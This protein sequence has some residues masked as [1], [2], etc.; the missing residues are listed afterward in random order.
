MVVAN[1]PNIVVINKQERKEV[2]VDTTIPSDRKIR[3]TGS[4]INTKG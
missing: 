3:N 4:L 1:Q 2:V